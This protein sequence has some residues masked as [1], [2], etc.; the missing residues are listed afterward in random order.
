MEFSKQQHAAL[1][2]V[3]QWWAQGPER[4]PFFRLDGYAGTGKSTI[5]AELIADIAGHV[6]FATFTGKAASVLARKGVENVSTIHKLIYK[7]KD[8]SQ[9]KLKSLELER[10]TLKKRVPEPAELI[11]KVEA[12]ITQEQENLKRPMFALNKE[13]SALL[14]AKALVIDEYSMVDEW[15]RDDLLSFNVPILLLGDPGQLPPVKG[16]SGF[17]AGKPDVMLTEIHRQAADSPIIRMATEVREGRALRYGDWGLGCE[18]VRLAD[19]DKAL[20]SKW[21]LEAD[22]LLVG[23]NL[24][25]INS[26]ARIRDLQGRTHWAPQTGD[27]L[28]CLRNNAEAGF[29]NGTTWMCR[30]DAMEVDDDTLLLKLRDDD[31]NDVDC[32]AHAHYFQG[33]EPKP[34]EI[35]NAECFDFGGAMTVHKAQGSQWDSVLIFDEWFMQN[36]KEWL[37]TGLTRAAKMVRVVHFG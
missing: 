17:T 14:T 31:G 18:V 29:L 8:K 32:L 7:P 6:P 37:Y 21:V 35:K 10:A 28:I 5:A 13:D 24:T 22:Q 25:R 34:Y 12:A 16:S 36:R 11:K 4:K 26:N 23:R 27:K 3:R 19:T 33:R 30:D 9:A 15:T 20:L 1:A 2:S